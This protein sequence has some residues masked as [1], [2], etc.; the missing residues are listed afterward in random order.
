MT[1]DRP[2]R[3]P[4]RWAAVTGAVVFVIYVLTLSPT[5]A[6]W[7]TSEYIAAAKVL[8][9]PH[10]PGNP[11]FTLMA[12]VW[13]LLPLASSY[14]M[15]IN[16]FAA[17]TSAAS[18]ALWFLVAERWLREIVPVRW[19]RIASAAAGTLVGALSWTVWNQSVVNEK[20]YTVSMLSIALIAWLA[21]RWADTE[22]GLRRD[23]LLVLIAYLLALTSTN[24]MM[25]VLA[26]PLVGIYVLWTDWRA[27]L[28]PAVIVGVISVVI[29]G[30]SI[31]YIYLPIR[32]GQYP[33]INEGEPVGFFSQALKDVLNRVQYGKPSVFE[34]QTGSFFDQLAN[35]WQ[36]WRWQ[37]ARDWTGVAPVATA[38]F[39]VLGVTGLWT[40]VRRDRR[41][42]LA[43]L[44]LFF[45]LTVLLIYYL[46]F[47]YGFSIYPD[48]TLEREVRERDYFF[49]ASF[50]FF[51]VLVALGF[52]ALMKSI[53]ESLRDRGTE[54]G[55]W[56]A[57]SS[58]LALAL[59]P[60]LGNRLTASRAG[61]TLAHDFAID[62]LQSVEPYG[63]LITAGD[64]D[65]FPLW[66]A[67]EVEGVRRDVTLANLSLMNTRWHLRQIRRRE[68]DPFQPGASVALWRPRPDEP[69]IELSDSNAERTSAARWPK[70]AGPVVSLTEEQL[71]DSLL[72]PDIG[73]APTQPL[74]F[75]NVVIRFGAQYL[76]LQDLMTA[77]LIRD[78]IGKRPIYFAWSAGGYPDQTLG[79][80]PYLVS[81]G[82]VRRVSDSVVVPNDSVVASAMLGYV[83]VPRSSELLW[84]AYHWQSATVQRPRGWVD[85]PSSS[86]LQ[87]YAIVYG[88]MTEVYN[89]RGNA[90]LAVRSDSIAAAVRANIGG[91]QP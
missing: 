24:H 81:Q 45:T 88:A 91:P 40:L 55:R 77:V 42:G 19:A 36:Y 11:L 50:S 12:H 52:G 66:F 87:L 16:L 90:E 1:V 39:T 56:A 23:H 20:V 61:E 74:Q 46:N 33:P 89:S 31:N 21:V 7:D 41:A 47:K 17:I 32:A 57:A 22:G 29:V 62:I 82:L 70:P 67:Q 14:A 68:A 38:I 58:V 54:R 64:N 35:Y 65:T 79:L 34:R 48:R 30:L 75:G 69:G 63:I 78:N 2:D 72:L 27:L 76:L 25:G 5:T 3:P 10:P 18:A 13:G 15:R 37:F 80:S 86:I 43:A 6:F 85:P 44:A 28:R 71:S 26:I 8:G 49:V 9:I 73:A 59:V 84:N 51:G 83:D 53:V 60:L 4:Y